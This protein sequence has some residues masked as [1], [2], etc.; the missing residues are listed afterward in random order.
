M[1]TN[2]ISKK[3]RPQRMFQNKLECRSKRNIKVAVLR[4]VYRKQLYKQLA[5]GS[6]SVKQLSELSDVFKFSNSQRFKNMRGLAP[7]TL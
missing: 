7:E 5:L 1:L 6:K 2:S 4:T 3:Q